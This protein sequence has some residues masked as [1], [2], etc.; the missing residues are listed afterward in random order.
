MDYSDKDQDRYFSGANES[1]QFNGSFTLGG[2]LYPAWGRRLLNERNSRK[3]N[4]QGQALFNKD[5]T[6]NHSIDGVLGFELSEDK[7]DFHYSSG[8]GESVGR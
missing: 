5:I 6:E 2:I 3:W 1:G 8:V 4:W 7:T